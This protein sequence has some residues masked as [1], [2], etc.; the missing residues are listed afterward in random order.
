M[1]REGYSWSVLLA[2]A[3]LFC[4]YYERR[5]LGRGGRRKADE[6]MDGCN[7]MEGAK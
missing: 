7:G 2:L 4:F 5:F 3:A 1:D 6:W